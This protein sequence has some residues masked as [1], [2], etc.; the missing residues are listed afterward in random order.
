MIVLHAEV[1]LQPAQISV[2]VV[3]IDL[4]FSRVDVPIDFNVG[5]RCFNIKHPF[6]AFAPGKPS[7]M[8]APTS[9]A[10]AVPGKRLS[11]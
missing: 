10:I 5:A 1:V 11:Q 3:D 4:H 6:L 9:I 7:A 2:L 8:H